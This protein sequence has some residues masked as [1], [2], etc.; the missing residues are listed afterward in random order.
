LFPSGTVLFK[1]TEF[2]VTNSCRNFYFK[3]SDCTFDIFKLFLLTKIFCVASFFNLMLITETLRSFGIIYAELLET[4]NVGAGYTAIILSIVI[5]LVAI[6]VCLIKRL[7]IYLNNT[8]YCRVRR[9]HRHGNKLCPCLCW[10]I[11]LFLCYSYEAA[12]ISRTK[13]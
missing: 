7:D 4:Y 3:D 13:H 12:L 6:G 1:L 2:I 9:V 5:F 8:L 11:L 10:S